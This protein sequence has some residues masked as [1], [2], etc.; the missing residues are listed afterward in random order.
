MIV[1][2]QEGATED[3]VQAV[4]DRM[5]EMDFT[6]HRS[7][8]MAHIVLG[9]VGPEQF[10]M[11]WGIDYARLVEGG[12]EILEGHGD[13]GATL[14]AAG[15]GVSHLAALRKKLE[16]EAAVLFA[17]R[18][19]NRAVNQAVGHLRDLRREQREA[20]VSAESW[21]GQD[22]AARGIGEGGESQAEAVGRH[23]ISLI[24]H[25]VN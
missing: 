2:M 6:I 11:F 15:S 13:L 9:G 18:G 7:T 16:E 23:A 17:P 5:V 10:R 12:R 20:T 19:Q 8:G 14:F 3:Q 4:I 22:R 21:A 1:V 24:N 25:L